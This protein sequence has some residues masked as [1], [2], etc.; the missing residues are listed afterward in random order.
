MEIS[1]NKTKIAV[2]G[3]GYVGFP[4]AM[5]FARAGF[6]VIGVR[7]NEELVKKIN[8]GYN[9]IKGKEPGLNELAKQVK[10]TGNF[11]ATTDPSV[12]R[13]ADVIIVAVETPVEANR[14]PSYSA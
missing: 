8:C 9:P 4:V 10:K 12:Y 11:L 3:L 1:K 5:L 13:E 2:C 14:Q 7:R 6:K